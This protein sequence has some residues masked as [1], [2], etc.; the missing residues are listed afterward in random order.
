MTD[1]PHRDVVAALAFRDSA[2]G[3]EFFICRRP[4]EK[5]NPLLWEFVG[6]KVEAGEDPRAALVRECREELAITPTVGDVYFEVDHEYDD[7][8]IHLTLYFASFCE[9]PTLL[10]HVEAAWILPEEI[11]QYAFCPADAAI[12]SKMQKDFT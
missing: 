1:K 2:R 9:E 11:P 6:G 12:L 5:S 8:F 3:R 4:P 10:E 7:I